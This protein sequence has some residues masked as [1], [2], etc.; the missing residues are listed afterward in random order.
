[1]EYFDGQLWELYPVEQAEPV[2]EDQYGNKTYAEYRPSHALVISSQDP[3]VL[4][5][6]DARAWLQEGQARITAGVEYRLKV[7]P[8][9]IVKTKE[10]K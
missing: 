2:S 3:L 4:Q 6:N 9:Q 7:T 10:E 5:T 8:V 1:M